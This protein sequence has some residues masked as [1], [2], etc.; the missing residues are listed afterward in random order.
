MNP[1]DDIRLL[2]AGGAAGEPPTGFA[3]RAVELPVR[4]EVLRLAVDVPDRP[5]RLA[6]IVPLVYAIDDR[7]MVIYLRQI[8]AYHKPIFCRK[9]CIACCGSYLIV[10]S[11]A[12]MY[13]Q[14]ERLASL[15]PA[16]ARPVWD[17][18]EQ[19]ARLA[20]ETGL[21]DRLKAAEPHEKPL[22]LIEQWW[23]QQDDRSC[24]FLRDGDCG[25]YPHR[26]VVCREFYSHTPPESCA[27][28]EAARMATPLSLVNTLW[29]LEQRLTGESGGALSL[30]LM[31]LWAEVRTAEAR[32]TWPA[33]R[34]VEEL[35]DCLAETA[36]EAGRLTTGAVV[37]RPDPPAP[38]GD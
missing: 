19:T 37:E 18:L 6:E 38:A 14:V 36:A 33:D 4:D 31:K 13:Y 22:D 2:D 9:G 16:E 12:E 35:F 24:C 32:R 8:G 11:P 23:R 27:A 3:R 29:Q 21:I 25:I 34:V 15:P 26:F 28:C 20:E 1:G 10:F 5:I 30:P 7:L 17:R